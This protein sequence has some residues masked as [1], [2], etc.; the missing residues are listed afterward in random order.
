MVND[1][2]T[3]ASQLFV[4]L[5]NLL[6]KSL[7]LNLELF[8][9][10]KMETLSELLL[11]LEDLLLVCKSVPQGDVLETIL[12]NFLILGF[13]GFFPVF[14]HLSAELFTSSAMDGVHGYTT[15]K[16]LELLLNLCALSLLLVQLVL[17][18]TSHA[19]VTVLSFLQV[20]SDLMHVSKSVQILMLV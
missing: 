1:F 8:V 6:V 3:E 9:I 12:M 14:D 2:S 10:D 13:I 11:L 15:L 16:L 20:I 18:F 7:I 19:I 5:F 4:S 17:K